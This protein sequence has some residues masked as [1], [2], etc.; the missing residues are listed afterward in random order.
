MPATATYGPTVAAPPPQLG[1]GQR[2]AAPID[3][4]NQ[5]LRA[6]PEYQKLIQSFGQNP[7]DV[8]LNDTQKQQVIRLAQSL[9]AVVDE[10]GNGQEVDDS[11]NFRAKGHGLRNTLIVAGLAGAALATAGAA[12]LFAPAAAGAAGGVESGVTAGLGSAALPGAGTALGGA[13]AAGGGAA[14]AGA[15]AAFDAA[16]NFIG[17]STI[18]TIGGGG[19]A[20]YGAA[21]GSGLTGDLLKYGLPTAGGLASSL[22]QANASGKASDAQQAYLQEALDYEKQQDAL[23]RTIAA[24]KVKLEAGRY[25]DYSGNIAPYLATGSAA[26]GRAS[27]LLGLP[28]G[29]APPGGGS[30]APGGNPLDYASKLSAADKSKVDALLKKYNS[31][32]DPNYWYGVNA[33]HGGFDATGADW[34]DMRIGK[35]DGAG[36]GYAG[37]TTPAPPAATPAPAQQT[38][39]PQARTTDPSA[40]VSLRAPDGSVKQVPADQA[41]HYLSLGATRVA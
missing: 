18:S 19:G 8:H 12:G 6:R 13:A 4:F 25:A 38:T 22:I 32:D 3:A 39:Q 29:S 17:P 35:G 2:S 21:T 26:A 37:V 34:N 36:K 23:N 15:G 41:D 40:T 27:S 20:T 5:W 28:A 16:G 14:A 9:G 30:S 10:G 7:N 1:Y 24:D 31:S 11:G 33:Q